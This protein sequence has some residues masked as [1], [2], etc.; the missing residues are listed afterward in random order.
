MT[1]PTIPLLLHVFVVLGMCLPSHCLATIGGIHAY[2]YTDCWEG[3]FKYAI[4]MGSVAMIYVPSFV[5]I[6][7]GIQKLL[8]G[9][10]QTRKSHKPTLGKS[11]KKIIP[12][13][14]C[15]LR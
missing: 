7:S 10:T 8:R 1:H 9:D 3:F 15:F 5:K 4:E 13:I 11:A 2:R 14:V 6:G 12:V